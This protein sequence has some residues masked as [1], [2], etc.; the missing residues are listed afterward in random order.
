MCWV[1][2]YYCQSAASLK[3]LAIKVSLQK[4]AMVFSDDENQRLKV[5]IDLQG[6]LAA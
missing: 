4:A 6:E 5:E 3:M 1:T 2:I